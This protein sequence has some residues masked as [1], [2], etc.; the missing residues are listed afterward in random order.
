M[1]ETRGP[2][3]FDRKVLLAASVDPGVQGARGAKRNSHLFEA[4]LRA[5]G[6]EMDSWKRFSRVS[7]AVAVIALFVV[8]VM[9][10]RQSTSLGVAIG[11]PARTLAAPF[12]QPAPRVPAS[13]GL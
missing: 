4:L 11:L 12:A 10:T 7:L 9:P 6:S 1:A 2:G 13:A 3:V 8:S 5:R